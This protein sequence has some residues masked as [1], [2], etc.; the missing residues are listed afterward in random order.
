MITT[1]YLIRHG[2]T[3][4]NEAGR[5]QGSSDIPLN[6]K[7]LTEA[8][9]VGKK[10]SEVPFNAIYSS[11]LIRAKQTAEEIAKHHSLPVLLVED[12]RE[13]SFGSIEGLTSGEIESHPKFNGTK[14]REWY[15][16]GGID[17]ESFDAMMNRTGTALSEIVK[18]HINETIG[19]AAHGGVIKSL[20]VYIGHI[21]R[22]VIPTVIIA[23]ASQIVIEYSHAENR[24][25]VIDFPF[26]IQH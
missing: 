26:S 17:G 8:R 4:W 11:P 9:E 18:K 10:L 12:M 25:T 7:G 14:K 23:N 15:L 1:I 21:K 3:D 5:Y 16:M 24:F 6:K 2:T 22:E 13:R 20:G 19:I